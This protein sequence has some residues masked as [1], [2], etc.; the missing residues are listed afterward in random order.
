MKKLWALLLLLAFAGGGYWWTKRPSLHQKGMQRMERGDL[1]GA[2][3][4]FQRALE[5]TTWAPEVEEEIRNEMARAYLMKGA[6]D[7]AEDVLKGTLDKFPKSAYAHLARGFI[8]LSKGFDAYAVESFAQA[9]QADP[10]DARPRI[11]LGGLYAFRGE[12]D[13]ARQEY[14]AALAGAPGDRGALLGLAHVHALCGR[15]PEAVA[16]YENALQSMPQDIR[17]RLALARTLLLSG[18]V[19]A[20]ETAARNALERS[21]DSV[22]GRILLGDILRDSGRG[23][24]AGEVYAALVAEDERNLFPLLR[25]ALWRARRGEIDQARALLDKAA[26]VLPKPAAGVPSFAS[27][28]EVEDALEHKSYVRQA[29]LELHLTWA[30][31]YA[32]QSLIA[33]AEREVQRALQVHSKD[34]PSL[35]CMTE[36]MRLRGDAESRLTWAGRALETAPDHCLALLDRA[37]ARISAGKA[38]DASADARLAED[39]CPALPRAPAVLAQAYLAAGQPAEAR[40]AAAEAGRRGDT[41]DA[42]LALGAVAMAAKRWDEAEKAFRRALDLDP[43]HAR[44]HYELGRA[45]SAARKPSSQA[46]FREAARLEP[47][48]YG[49]AAQK[50]SR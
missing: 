38:K 43:Y 32:M 41:T 9:V 45:L 36:I 50:A 33:D 37:E 5:K 23:E 24:G 34:M 25:L 17:T 46:S 18:D 39:A 21:P 22:P 11:G 35:R 27:L 30:R 8:F 12:F 6:L 42:H 47:A 20:A 31:F 40:G 49:F 28:S 2:L 10:K 16:A 29:M 3:E 26:Q 48:V 7:N 14:E 13:P 1:D 44:A 19:D 15:Y 4:T